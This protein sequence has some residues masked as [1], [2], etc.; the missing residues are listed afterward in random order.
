MLRT[1]LAAAAVTAM[2]VFAGSAGAVVGGTPDFAHPYVGFEDDG[3]HAC[4]GTL[5]TGGRT[6]VTAAHCFAGTDSY[7]GTARDGAPIIRVTFAQQGIFDH[8]RTSYLGRYYFDPGF[9]TASGKGLPGFDT[10]DVAVIVF[11]TPIAMSQYGRLPALGQALQTSRVDIVG[12]GVQNFA[13]PDP[14]DPSCK[15]QEGDKWTRYTAPANVVNAES[16]LADEFIKLSATTSQGKGGTC[17]GDSG[18]PDLV[19]GTNVVVA[20]NS[21]AHDFCNGISYSYRLDTPQ[22]QNFLAAYLH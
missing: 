12:Y 4:S 19:A 11:D 15:P 10:H 21:F 18:G 3:F 2:L 6:M 7:W 17:F 13:K 22:A 16:R 8:T 9:L 14:C 1:L 20:E 5:L